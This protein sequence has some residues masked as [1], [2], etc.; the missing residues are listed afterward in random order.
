MDTQIEE[1]RIMRS[2]RMIC[3]KVVMVE[4]LIVLRPASVMA[5]TT[6]KRESVY[7]MLRSGFEEP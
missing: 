4:R 2:Q 5:E 7:E 3:W 6:K 1:P